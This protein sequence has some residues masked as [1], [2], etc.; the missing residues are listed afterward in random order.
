MLMDPF[1]LKTFYELQQ[2]CL[3]LH[4]VKLFSL[5]LEMLGLCVTYGLHLRLFRKSSLALFSC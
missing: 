5:H 4:V 3:A 1:Q 2:P